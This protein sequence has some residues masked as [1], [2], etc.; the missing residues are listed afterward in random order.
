MNHTS[1]F[2][3]ISKRH[4]LRS[5]SNIPVGLLFLLTVLGVLFILFVVA[6]IRHMRTRNSNTVTRS[7]LDGQYYG[8]YIIPL[9][10]PP[11]Y[12]DIV[13]ETSINKVPQTTSPPSYEQ[14]I[15]LP[16]VI[17]HQPI[18]WRQLLILKTNNKS[19]TW[20]RIKLLNFRHVIP[21]YWRSEFVA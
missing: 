13:K 21:F 3:G 19:G 15:A 16:N 14:T 1:L 5:S 8:P 12:E 10:H 17:N 20:N 11:S 6:V 9:D 18:I 7:L 4:L 2:K